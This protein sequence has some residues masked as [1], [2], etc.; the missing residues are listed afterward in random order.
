MAHSARSSTPLEAAFSHGTSGLWDRELQCTAS[1]A[2]R[3]M[4]LD[5]A[6]AAHARWL[7]VLDDGANRTTAVSD[8]WQV[9]LD[10]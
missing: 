2:G 4:I 10:T 9:R 3:C 6:V 7:G 1:D 8:H 5:G